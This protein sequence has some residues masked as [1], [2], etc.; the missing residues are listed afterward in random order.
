ML[1]SL[2]V[3]LPTGILQF[4]CF[5]AT[6]YYYLTAFWVKLAALALALMFTFTIRRKVAMIAAMQRNPVRDKL[7]A[8]V[9]LTLWS[10]VAVAGRLIGLP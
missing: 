2:A 4:M 3:L 9:S 5:A 1:L 6:K 10:S 7:V 8:A